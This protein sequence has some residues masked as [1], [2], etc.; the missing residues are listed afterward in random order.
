MRTHDLYDLRFAHWT[1]DL[2]LGKFL[3]RVSNAVG[4]RRGRT[5]PPAA[6]Q[7]LKCRI[8][9]RP[10]SYVL[11]DYAGSQMSTTQFQRSQ[12]PS[13]WK[14]P[15]GQG[16]LASIVMLQGYYATHSMLLHM[17]CTQQLTSPP[18]LTPGLRMPRVRKGQH[19][20]EWA[21]ACGKNGSEMDQTLVTWNVQQLHIK[22]DR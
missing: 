22:D 18:H 20:H 7:M 5:I 11:I 13:Q 3:I 16:L 8:Y 14:L 17:C 21:L 4:H 1:Q 10:S 19:Q 2:D 12:L 15:S 6:A 9:G